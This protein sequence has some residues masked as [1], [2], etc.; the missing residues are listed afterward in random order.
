LEGTSRSDTSHR[1][2]KKNIPPQNFTPMPKFKRAWD[3]YSK[4]LSHNAILEGSK[5]GSWKSIGRFAYQ[6][7]VIGIA[8]RDTRA[9]SP[10]VTYPMAQ[11]AKIGNCL[12]LRNHSPLQ[13]PPGSRLAKIHERIRRSA[14]KVGMGE[15][16]EP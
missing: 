16:D 11:K 13:L 1:K 10:T 5:G 9:Q 14:L 4:T 12:H 3:V 6:V 7:F 2:K 8:T 15:W